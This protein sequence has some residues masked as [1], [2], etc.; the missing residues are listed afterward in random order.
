MISC[1]SKKQRQR[2]RLHL[3][4]RQTERDCE[5]EANKR[6]PNE[7]TM[8][9]QHQASPD[10]PIESFETRGSANNIAHLVTAKFSGRNLYRLEEA[11]SDRNFRKFS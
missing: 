9:S 8:L 4:E 1:G 10:S 7:S 3:E 5:E 6:K 2:Q 11:G